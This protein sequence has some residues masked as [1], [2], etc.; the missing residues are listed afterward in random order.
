LCQLATYAY[1]EDQSKLQ[2]END[3]S[4]LL[5]D[6][7]SMIICLRAK[8]LIVA[9]LESGRFE[10]CSTLVFKNSNPPLRE[11]IHGKAR[12]QRY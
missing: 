5:C 12:D 10:V 3:S 11:E 7:Q 1:L 8:T 2:P 4:R 6:I 9:I